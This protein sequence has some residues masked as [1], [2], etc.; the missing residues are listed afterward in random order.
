MRIGISAEIMNS[1][2]RVAATPSSVS[3]LVKDGHEVFIQARAG[4]GASF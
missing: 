4:V 1:E 2:I 3:T